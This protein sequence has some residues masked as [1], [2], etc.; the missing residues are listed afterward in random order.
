VSKSE[1]GGL[2]EFP[3]YDC[4]RYSESSFSW[5]KARS[6]GLRVRFL[7]DGRTAIS[8]VLRNIPDVRKKAIHLPAYLCRAIVQPFL[9]QGLRI[10]FYGHDPPLRPLIDTHITDGVIFIIDYFGTEAVKERDLKEMLSRGNS[11]ILDVT[12]SILDPKRFRMADP[13]LYYIASLRKI[14]P[15]PDGGIVYHARERFG[16]RYGR[17][18]NYGPMVEAMA[19]KR[20]YRDSSIP[21]GDCAMAVKE[22]FLSRYR[23]FELEKDRNRVRIRPLPAISQEILKHTDVSKMIERRWENLSHV[24]RNFP[25]RDLLLFDFREIRSPFILPLV[26]PDSSQRD[27]TRDHL[28]SQG[29]FPPVHWDIGGIVPESFTLEHHLSQTLLSVPI[30][31]RYDLHDINRI[32]EA[33]SAVDT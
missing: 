11:V 32:I 23:D 29:I 10:R 15:I 9:E 31:Q 27:R 6:Q 5:L 7:S 17:C 18:G 28:V 20:L 26:F 24:C 8:A 30:D 1:I 22:S 19:A 4:R 33:L 14:F 12:H 25:S 2:Y 3:D 13:D 16:G 21:P